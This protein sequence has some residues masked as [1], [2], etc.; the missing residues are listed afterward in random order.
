MIKKLFN[1]LHAVIRWICSVLAIPFVAVYKAIKAGI[2]HIF[3]EVD[4]LFSF[5]ITKERIVFMT[6]A[7]DI[8]TIKA[9]VLTPPTVNVDLS[10]VAKADALASVALD[11]TAIKADLTLTPPAA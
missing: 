8:A 5:F 4:R 11:V 1:Y 6:I 3:T 2:A 7:D 9:A 10:T